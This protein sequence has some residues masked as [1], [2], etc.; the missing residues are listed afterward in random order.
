M[1]I[2]I[3]V[4]C[5]IYCQLQLLYINKYKWK[6]IAATALTWHENFVIFFYSTKFLLIIYL[7]FIYT[8][9]RLGHYQGSPSVNANASEEHMNPIAF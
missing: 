7:T 1:L 4:I 9:I 3:H 2:Y 6:E 5:I 8:P